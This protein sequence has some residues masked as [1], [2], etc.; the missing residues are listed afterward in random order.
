VFPV[1][2][3]LNLYISLRKHLVFKGLI[4]SLYISFL[5][6][7]FFFLSVFVLFSHERAFRPA[8]LKL[9]WFAAH[10]KTYTNFLA[11]FV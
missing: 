7:H 9:F 2:Y 10:C 11:H 1:R 5:P 3:K 4:L 8:V 6:F